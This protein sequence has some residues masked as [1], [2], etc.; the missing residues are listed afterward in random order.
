MKASS[1]N[2]FDSEETHQ[3]RSELTVKKETV[4]RGVIIKGVVRN[5]QTGVEKV[6]GKQPVKKG[7]LKARRAPMPPGAGQGT[8]DSRKNVSF[9][10]SDSSNST[11]SSN[12][13]GKTSKSG[14]G[15]PKS[16]PKS[17]KSRASCLLR[18]K[19]K[20]RAPAVPLRPKSSAGTL[21]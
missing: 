1:Q 4:V 18:N 2:S 17:K 12:S 5:T 10:Y 11:L 19:S 6:V 3:T 21:P 7:S 8:I 13:S 20:S 16:V 14:S 15:S 9:D